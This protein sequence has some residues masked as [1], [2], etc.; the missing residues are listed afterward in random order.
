MADNVTFK[1]KG[2]STPQE[3]TAVATDDVGGVHYQVLKLDVGGDGVSV[4]VTDIATSAKQ[5]PPVATPT[6]YNVTLTVA[7]TEYS[8]A[9][10]AN[11]REF[12]FRGRTLYDVRYSFSTGKVA[13]PTAPYLTLPAGSDYWSDNLNLASTTLYLAS[14]QADVVIEIEEWV[15]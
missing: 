9:L 7:D 15:A 14:S 10:T 2:R 8:Q 6:A 1:F 5:Q 12:R 13:T 4:P 3:N 11:T